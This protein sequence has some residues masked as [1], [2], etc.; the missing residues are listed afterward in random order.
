MKRE[1]QILLLNSLIEKTYREEK[2][3][4]GLSEKQISRE[5]EKLTHLKLAQERI[6]HENRQVL[7]KVSYSYN[8]NGSDA[9]VE[10]KP[11]GK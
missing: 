11:Q 6:N 2:R 8:A 10:D 5:I 3:S 4:L 9:G 1:R 7:E